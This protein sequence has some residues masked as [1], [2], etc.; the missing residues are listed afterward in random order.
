MTH[1]K[2]RPV[3]A[4]QSGPGL[5]SVQS[6]PAI[7]GHKFTAAA[8]TGQGISGQTSS[9]IF[10]LARRAGLPLSTAAAVAL[11]NQFGEIR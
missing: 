11:A 4:D 8:L 2:L 5:Q 1:W 9:A 6:S 3:S 7:D 10:W